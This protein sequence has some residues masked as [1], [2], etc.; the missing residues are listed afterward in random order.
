M[1]IVG[2]WLVDVYKYSEYATV[3]NLISPK[4]KITKIDLLIVAIIKKISLIRL[5]LGGAAI[6]AQENINHQNDMFGIIVSIPFVN[7]ILRVIVILYLMLA[8]QN[9]AEEL[10]PWAIIIDSLACI[11]NLELDNIPA[12]ISPMCPTEEYAISDFISDCRKQIMDV[13]TPPIK[14]IVITGPNNILFIKLNIIIIR[15]NPYPPSFSKIAAKIMDPATGASTWALG[16]HKWTEN[17][18]NFTRNAPIIINQKIVDGFSINI[19][20]AIVIFKCFESL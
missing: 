13:I 6:L 3:M 20:S 5:I 19:W 2:P 7:K 18:G 15:A 8:I 1:F 12:I 14:A 17:S 10:N 16:S 11:P 4:G 9:S